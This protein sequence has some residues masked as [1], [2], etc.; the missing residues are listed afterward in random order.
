MSSSPTSGIAASGCATVGSSAG[1]ARAVPGNA[2]RSSMTQ[3]AANTGRTNERGFGVASPTRIFGN[4][5]NE[6]SFHPVS[7]GLP[8][9][10]EA[11]SKP[12]P[13]A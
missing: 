11:T 3:V 7:Y 10:S 13:A 9:R 1:A 8:R 6:H 5:R 12:V 2:R 4:A